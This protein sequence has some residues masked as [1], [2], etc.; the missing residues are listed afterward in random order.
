MLE[1]FRNGEWQGYN[2][3]LLT[4]N[5][6]ITS[7]NILLTLDIL[8]LYSGYHLGGAG[9]QGSTCN[10]YF[11]NWGLIS[12]AVNI[13]TGIMWVFSTLDNIYVNFKVALF[14]QGR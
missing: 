7:Y 10:L 5:P 9:S 2:L 3:Q 13:T 6:L 11:P 14:V 4:Y 8:G 12:I 1:E